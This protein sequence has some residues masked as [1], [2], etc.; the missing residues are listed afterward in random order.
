MKK[1]PLYPRILISAGLLMVTMPLLFKEY[2]PIPDF[3][4]GFLL[5]A[6]GV[7]EIAGIVLMKRSQK[8]GACS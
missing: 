7:F 3:V 6:G 8:S 2:L 1:Q 4:R 5:G